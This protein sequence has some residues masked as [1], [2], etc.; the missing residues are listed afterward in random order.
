MTNKWILS[1]LLTSSLPIFLI[2]CTGGKPLSTI[3]FGENDLEPWTAQITLVPDKSL[4]SW[5]SIY[6]EHI[7]PIELN[8]LIYI[9]QGNNGVPV[10]VCLDALNPTTTFMSSETYFPDKISKSWKPAKIQCGYGPITKA[11]SLN[12]TVQPLVSK[13][14]EI[15]RFELQIKS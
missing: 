2:G 9:K 4:S 8:F 5:N 14:V 7:Q 3:K 15:K 12:I 6:L 13:P 11:C 10:R 1:Q